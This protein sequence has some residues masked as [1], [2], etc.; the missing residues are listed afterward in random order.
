MTDD[1]MR[2]AIAEYCGWKHTLATQQFPI[3]RHGMRL[4][5]TFGPDIEAFWH[6]NIEG[7]YASP[8]DYLNDLNAMHEAEKTLKPK[9]GLVFHDYTVNLLEITTKERTHTYC[10]TARQRASAFCS[11]FG[12]LKKTHDKTPA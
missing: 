2:I 11:M 6:P 8:P 7:V 5:N 1:E 12:E 9:G 4:P 3:V 10:A